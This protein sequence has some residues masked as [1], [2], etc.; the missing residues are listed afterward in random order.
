MFIESHGNESCDGRDEWKSARDHNPFDSLG[1]LETTS[2]D[3]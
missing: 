3:A 2:H 1:S